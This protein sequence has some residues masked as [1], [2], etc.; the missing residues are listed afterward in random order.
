MHL[1]EHHSVL[2]EL[3]SNLIWICA[4]S[5]YIVLILQNIFFKNEVKLIFFIRITQKLAENCTT[6]LY[7][8]K[9]ADLLR[10]VANEYEIN[11][12]DSTCFI[13]KIPITKIS[14]IVA[15]DHSFHMKWNSFYFKPWKP[16]IRYYYLYTSNKHI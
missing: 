13:N 4:M 16:L 9:L 14:K 11:K 8:S 15:G 1:Y 7:F 5:F 3:C 2:D 10:N 6:T 12:M